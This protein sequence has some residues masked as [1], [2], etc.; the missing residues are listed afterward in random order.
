MFEVEWFMMRKK[1]RKCSILIWRP[2]VVFPHSILLALFTD[3]WKILRFVDITRSAWL[4]SILILVQ[5]H[6]CEGFTAVTKAGILLSLKE[7]TLW[8]Q[9]LT[10]IFWSLFLAMELSAEI[11]HQM[12]CNSDV[13]FDLKKETQSKQSHR[14]EGLW[15]D[16]KKC[17][18]KLS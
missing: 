6:I 8:A 2:D 14:R 1:S 16:E 17:W 3:I 15:G 7:F 12:E 5:S 10:C 11:F 13:M 4:V 18:K 9:F